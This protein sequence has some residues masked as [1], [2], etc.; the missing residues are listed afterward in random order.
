MAD[1]LDSRLTE[2]INIAVLADCSVVIA[3]KDVNGKKLK[4]F[5]MKDNNTICTEELTYM[6]F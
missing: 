5:S 3:G 6:P 4:R 2:V 1:T